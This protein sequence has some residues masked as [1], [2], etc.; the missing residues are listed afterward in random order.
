MTTQRPNRRDPAAP[1]AQPPVPSPATGRLMYVQ[2]AGDLAETW[3]RLRLDGP[4]F[5]GNQRYLIESIVGVARLFGQ[6][7]LLTCAGTL[8]APQTVEDAIDAQCLG[9]DP[10]QDP[11]GLIAAVEQFGPT[12]L[13]VGFPHVGLLTWTGSRRSGEHGVRKLAVF[14]DSFNGRSPRQRWRTRRLVH[15]LNR[16]DVTAVSNH[17]RNATQALIRL[18]VDAAKV[19]AWDYPRS[20]AVPSAV[21]RILRRPDSPWRVVFVGNV[22]REKGVDCLLEAVCRMSSDGPGV[23]VTV[24]GDGDLEAYRSMTQRLGI[25]HS[26]T[27]AGRV[28]N[29]DVV[30]AMR[31]ADVVAVPSLHESAEGFPLTALEALSVRTPIAASDHPMFAGILVDGRTAAV[32]IAGD[33]ASLQK[34]L[35]RLLEDPDLYQRVSA[36]ADEAWAATLVESTWSDVAMNW[37]AAPARAA[38]STTESE[39]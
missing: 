4:E 38:T 27:F 28:R 3:A 29:P 5:Y 23:E 26:V 6:A 21:P 8:T 32:H 15:T 25:D 9:I 34:S 18:G 20:R 24:I 19:T 2:Y 37:A 39:R 13:I 16:P 7:R 10:Y 35:T 12:H 14:A 22:C 31:R 1:R 36:N 11:A 33:A 30:E 17:G